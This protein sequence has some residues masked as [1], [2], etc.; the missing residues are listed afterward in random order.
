M[1]NIPKGS[2]SAIAGKLGQ[3]RS[4]F[5]VIDGKLTPVSVAQFIEDW[6][7]DLVEALVKSL[8]KKKKNASGK[9]AG[10]IVY[11]LKYFGDFFQFTLNMDDY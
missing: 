9:L 11:D 1:G 6:G 10:S 8:D 2:R 3:A 5:A 4:G 7:G